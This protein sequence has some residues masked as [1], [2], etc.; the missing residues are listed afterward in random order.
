[1]IQPFKL[2]LE[3]YMDEIEK[4]TDGNLDNVELLVNC[5]AKSRSNPLKGDFLLRLIHLSAPLHYRPINLRDLNLIWLN[6]T[7]KNNEDEERFLNF[8]S[9]SPALIRIKNC[10]SLRRNATSLEINANKNPDKIAQ[11]DHISGNQTRI[12]KPG[13]LETEYT[14]INK[15]SEYLFKEIYPASIRKLINLRNPFKIKLKSCIADIQLWT[16]GS[17]DNV[18]LLVN[19]ISKYPTN[20]LK[21]NFLIRLLYL[22]ESA[23]E[24]ANHK[25]APLELHYKW[26]NKTLK[27]TEDKERFLNFIVPGMSVYLKNHLPIEKHSHNNL[28]DSLNDDGFRC[29]KDTNLKSDPRAIQ[30]IIVPI[31]DNIDML[32]ITQLSAATGENIIP[33]NAIICS[34]GSPAEQQEINFPSDGLLEK[35]PPCTNL[36]HRQNRALQEKFVFFDPIPVLNSTVTSA[37][38]SQTRRLHPVQESPISPPPQQPIAPQTPAGL[39]Q[40]HHI[41]GQ[42]NFFQPPDYSDMSQPSFQEINRPSDAP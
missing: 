24:E 4:W 16:Q 13:P 10:L 34:E 27:T 26:I 40:N 9:N 39:H 35:D 42:Y 1:V 29:L 30:A 5:I 23:P 6:N 2:K 21:L 37:M 7:L 38:S 36:L 31:D 19:C 18:E 32:D 8:L 11:T 33:V 14:T 20:P 22:T 3:V 12:R 15:F 25:N 17:L 28:R 41:S